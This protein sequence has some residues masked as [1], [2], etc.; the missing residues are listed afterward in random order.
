MTKVWGTSNVFTDSEASQSQQA[1][2][3]RERLL[4]RSLAEVLCDLGG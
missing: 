3:F 2:R 4:L 1:L